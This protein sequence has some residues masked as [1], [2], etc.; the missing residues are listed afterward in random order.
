MV[1]AD[2]DMNYDYYY[3]NGSTYACKVTRC[4]GKREG[5]AVMKNKDG[6]L[7]AK[8]VYSNDSLN[9]ICTRY[10]HDCK[11]ICTVKNNIMDGCY[12]EYDI[13][14][15]S[16]ISQ[17]EYN[18]GIRKMDDVYH[19][20]NKCSAREDNQYMN[21]SETSNRTNRSWRNAPENNS[22]CHPYQQS[23]NESSGVSSFLKV[24]A[25]AFAIGTALVGLT[26][27]FSSSHDDDR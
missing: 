8:L 2:Q 12:W 23:H 10:F 16:I 6:E 26:K 7:I 25:T 15:N 24:G 3:E 5:P 27:L 20:T 1:L 17:G 13:H 11:L 22:Y 9:G 4:N 21:G 18:D 19:D 14:N